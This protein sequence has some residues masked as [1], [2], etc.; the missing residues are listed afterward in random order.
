MTTPLEYVSGGFPTK[1][2]E[3]LLSGVPVVSTSAGEIEK[4][5]T[6][7][8]NIFLSAIGD[9][10]GIAQNIL[11][12][13]QNVNQA[14]AIGE[15]GKNLALKVFNADTYSKKIIEFLTSFSN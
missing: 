2:G 1:L 6:H 15:S 10:D 5:L 8:E 3:Y 13:D 4:Y 7:N 12:I 14:A 9:L 11:F